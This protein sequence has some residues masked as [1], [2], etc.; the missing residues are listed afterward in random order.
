MWHS[1]PSP[2][3]SRT[4]SGHMLASAS[5]SRP[6]YLASRRRADLLDDVVRL[7][8][9][10][11]AGA[12]ALDQV[13]NGVEPE[14]VDAHVEPELH[15]LEHRVEHLRVVEVQVGLVAEEAVPEVLLRHRVPGPV[16]LL[17]VGEDD[18]RAA[19]QLGVVAPDVEVALGR[20]LGRLARGL[21]PGVLVRGVVDDQ[22]GDHAQAALVRLVHEGAEVVQ[23]AVGRVHVLVVGDVVAV[24]AQRRRVERQQPDRVDAQRLHVVEPLASGRESRRCRRRWCRHRP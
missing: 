1:S 6:G 16:R 10:L 19:V 3:Y 5:S 7:A 21:E 8:Q 11:V 17:G 4:S 9:V 2:K 14:A 13:G 15:R 12:V 22:L 20:A 23:R 18:A 24:V